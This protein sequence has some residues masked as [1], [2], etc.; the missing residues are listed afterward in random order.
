MTE[1]PRDQSNKFNILEYFENIF[2]EQNL[3][4]QAQYETHRKMMEQYDRLASDARTPSERMFN[5]MASCMISTEDVATS[6]YLLILSLLNVMAAAI[7]LQ[8]TE[9][10]Q[11]QQ[12]RM[13]ELERKAREAK[14][15]IDKHLAKRL[16]ELLKSEGHEAMYG[17]GKET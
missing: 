5:M 12:E 4:A 10:T 17:T 7:E 2:N 9:L 3:Q 1:T 16:S 13:V 6:H 11:V 8:P 14:G 15:E